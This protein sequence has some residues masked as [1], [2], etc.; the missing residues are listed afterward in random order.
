MTFDNYYSIRQKTINWFINFL[1]E[2]INCTFENQVRQ[3]NSKQI[4]N[5]IMQDKYAI[6]Q[7]QVLFDY[8]KICKVKFDDQSIQ[9]KL[10]LVDNYIYQRAN[11]CWLDVFISFQLFP[12]VMR[13]LPKSNKYW[14][15]YLQSQEL[16][17]IL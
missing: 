16:L 5:V 11:N 6:Y 13:Y 3:L 4:F 15:N 2:S 1:D 9:N 7:F 12:T 10:S 8:I 17:K 14:N